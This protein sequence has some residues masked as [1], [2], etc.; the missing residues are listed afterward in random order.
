MI[1]RLSPFILL[2]AGLSCAGPSGA[3]AQAPAPATAIPEVSPPP[4]PKVLRDV[5]YKS[6][7][8]KDL[9]LDLYLPEGVD[10]PVPLILLVHGG[11][12]G[13]GSKKDYGGAGL[14]Y[15][16]NGYAAAAVDYRLS[17]EAPFPA[18]IE[19]VKAAVRWLR[20][21]AGDYNLDAAHFGAMGHS[22][23]GHLVSLLGTS[24]DL[25]QFDTGDNL[26]ESSKV[27]AVVDMAG[28]ED[29][30]AFFSAR[31]GADR[32]VALFGGSINQK[33]DLAVLAS[34]IDHIGPQTPP[35]LIISGLADTAVGVV[36]PKLFYVALQ[37]AGVPCMLMLIPGVPHGIALD[38]PYGKGKL[39]DSVFYF[40]DPLLKP[41]KAP[42]SA[43]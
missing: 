28:P 36:Q 24:G 7:N 1:G 39:W 43:T 23:G 26:A 11:G 19:D 27:Q 2:L 17:R 31:G 25:A 33:R 8:G 41:G 38:L 15:V 21:H 29:L 30:A 40:L 42:A 37:K 9:K 18:Q 3:F 4:P 32:P 10:H 14:E 6:V 22:A 13:A 12:W 35:F 16:K 34:P 5:T 20:A